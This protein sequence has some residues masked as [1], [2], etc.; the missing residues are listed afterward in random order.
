MGKNILDLFERHAKE[1]AQ[2]EKR[3]QKAKMLKNER[4]KKNERIVKT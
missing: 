1:W 3:K 4:M 2:N